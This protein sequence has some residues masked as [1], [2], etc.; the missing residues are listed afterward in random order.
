MLLN[1]LRIAFGL[2]ATKFALPFI[3]LRAVLFSCLEWTG[4]LF[5]LALFFFIVCKL[6]QLFFTFNKDEVKILKLCQPQVTWE[7]RKFNVP[8]MGQI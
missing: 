3:H 4:Q 8:P 1:Y 5:F 6:R 7:T 2:R